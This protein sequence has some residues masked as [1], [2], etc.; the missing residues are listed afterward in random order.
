M[1]KIMK[2][3]VQWFLAAGGQRNPGGSA[4]GMSSLFNILLNIHSQNTIRGVA[5]MKGISCIGILIIL[6]YAFNYKNLGAETTK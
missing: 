6:L 5:I 4:L 2:N 1:L 3:T